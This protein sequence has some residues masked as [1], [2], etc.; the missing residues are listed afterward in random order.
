MNEK[1]AIQ[2]LSRD[3]EIIIKPADEGGAIVL[4]NMDD[5]RKEA[6]RQLNDTD[7]YWKLKVNPTQEFQKKILEVTDMALQLNWISKSEHDFLNCRHPV[8]PVFYMLPKIH[9]SLVNP[10]G[11]P[12]VASRDSVGASVRLC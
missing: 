3:S 4:Q 9:K 5:Y 7:F 11:R 6:Y 8:V 1:L 10:K 12:I 2:E